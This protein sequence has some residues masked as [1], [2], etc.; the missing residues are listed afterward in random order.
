LAVYAK[1]RWRRESLAH[2]AA[3]EEQALEMS[4]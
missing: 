3:T 2:S 4:K 1:E